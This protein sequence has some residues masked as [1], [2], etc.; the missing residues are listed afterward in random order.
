MSRKQEPEA[1]A[2]AMENRCFAEGI[3][4]REKRE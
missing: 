2:S 1:A 3:G 4:Q